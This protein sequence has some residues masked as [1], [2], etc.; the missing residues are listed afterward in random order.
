MQ[1]ELPPVILSKCPRPVK[2]VSTAQLPP[3]FA[4]FETGDIDYLPVIRSYAEFR[5]R[6][7]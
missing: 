1:S 2:L 6:T 4:I 3:V 5:R 7:L